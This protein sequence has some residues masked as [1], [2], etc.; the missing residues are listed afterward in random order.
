MK[1]SKKEK[2][3]P[4]PI[5]AEYN[6]EK[7]LENL[8][9]EIK[10][11]DE[12]LKELNTRLVLLEKEKDLVASNHKIINKNFKL[13]KITWAFEEDPE[14]I[15]NTRKINQITLDKKMLDYATQLDRMK[16]MV[17]SVEKQRESLISERDRVM[18][19]E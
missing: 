15:E 14:Y 3:V 5:G 17:E 19:S 11:V 16:N 12:Q 1:K 2:E 8:N 6:K 18:S 13:L 10:T 4:A 7:H 9:R